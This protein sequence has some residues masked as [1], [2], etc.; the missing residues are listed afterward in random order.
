M[1]SKKGNPMTG[2]VTEKMDAFFL[3][4]YYGLPIFLSI[5]YMMF[6]Y[7]NKFGNLLQQYFNQKFI[8]LFINPII[9]LL[10]FIC[11]PNFLLKIFNDGIAVGL[12]TLWNFIPIL[13]LMNMC[14]LFLENCGYMV[15]VVFL[16]DKCN[17]ARWCSRS[18]KA[19]NAS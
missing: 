11:C 16:L 10:N 12:E 19:D 6:L 8:E 2:A 3:H 7:I 14:L 13:F 5:I 9:N 15:R 17:E 4:K 18:D 1:I